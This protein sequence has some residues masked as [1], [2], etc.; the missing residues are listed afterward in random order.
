MKIIITGALGHIGSRLIRDIPQFLR[1]Y[2]FVLIDNLFTERYASLFQLPEDLN[3]TFLHSDIFEIDYS[4]ILKD[5]IAVIHLAAITDAERSVDREKEVNRINFNGTEIIAR[6][7]AKNSVPFI[8]ISTTSVYGSQKDK[9]DETC[10]KLYPQSPYA[11]S[12]LNA[13]LLLKKLSLEMGLKFVILRFGTIFG[14][15]IGMRFHTAVN[16]FCWQ[17]T[18][19]Q[20]ITIWE[21]AYDQYRPY[22]DITDATT[23]I[24]HIIEKK[25]FNNDIY[26]A[27]TTNA[28]VRDIVNIIS[29]E[30]SEVKIE[31][32]KS[33]IMNQLSYHV[34]ANRIQKLGF[35]FRGNLTKG[36]QETMQQL[37]GI[38]SKFPIKVIVQ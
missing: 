19:N 5:T 32:V 6:A 34:V 29:K 30:V 11:S 12:K 21:T 2:Q 38:R 17:A 13:E 24:Y 25:L 28:T 37:H 8:M 18:L 33:E 4:D 15:S 7:C 22:L 9:V 14:K 1:S 26:N 36:V 3:Y 31:F 16:K 20:P 10:E 27:V 35:N 23:L